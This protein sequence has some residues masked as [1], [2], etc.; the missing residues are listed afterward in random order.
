MDV[1]YPKFAPLLGWCA[2]SGMS[3]TGTYNA[4]G[5]GDLKAIKV[6]T[7]TMIDVDAGLAWLRSLPPPQIRQQKSDRVA[8]ASSTEAPRATDREPRTHTSDIARSHGR[9]ERHAVTLRKNAR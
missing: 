4:L 8:T 1:P 9:F 7:R 5:S 6:G 2:L 3:R